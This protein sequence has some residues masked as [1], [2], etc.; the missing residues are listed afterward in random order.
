MKIILPG[1]S[2]QIGTL[3]AR[4]FSNDGHEVSVLSRRRLNNLPWK[5]VQWDGKN[6]GDW[7]GEF[8][9]ADAV[10][11]LT[12]RSVNCRYNEKNRRLIIESRINSVRAIDQAIRHAA[13]P[14]GTW[15]QAATAT[16]YTHRY[17]APNDEVTGQMD[18]PE[19]AAP[20]TW[21]FSTEVAH[22]W[23]RAI[24]EAGPLARTRKVVLRSAMTMSAD[25]GGVFDVLLRL[26][27]H[28][29]GGRAGDGR[30][31]VSWIHELDFVRAIY[32][33]IQHPSLDGPV[34][35]C[36]PAPLGNDEFMKILRDTWGARFGLPA[37]KLMLEVG[38]FFLR[39]ETELILKSRR[40]YP[41]R[42]IDDGFV[43]TFPNWP[44]AARDL[45]QRWRSQH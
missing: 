8:E 15:L 1:G 29:L 45:I 33:L 22:S 3:L 19:R 30:Q 21:R 16:I 42:L 5:V 6:P 17:D 14:P 31:Y 23:E 34:N 10:I 13:H 2:G 4:A 41:K 26:V 11:N 43:F 39:T 7:A 38:A 32:Y 25:S 35:I 12:G 24:N 27:R 37:S 18:G 40:V 28:G 36:S 9:N 44:D 20:E